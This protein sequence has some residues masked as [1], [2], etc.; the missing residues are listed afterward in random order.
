M[1]S[2]KNIELIKEK[3]DAAV[4]ATS[5]SSVTPLIWQHGA[6]EKYCI[7]VYVNSVVDTKTSKIQMGPKALIAAPWPSC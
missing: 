5:A 2:F 4:S 3:E 1:K 7:F 6:K